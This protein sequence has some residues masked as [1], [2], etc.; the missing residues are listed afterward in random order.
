MRGTVGRVVVGRVTST[1]VVRDHHRHD[2]VTSGPVLCLFLLV[3]FWCVLVCL[4]V[5][6]LVRFSPVVWVLPA[7]A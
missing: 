3:L 2:W 4:H 5:C 7:A 6:T 1:V